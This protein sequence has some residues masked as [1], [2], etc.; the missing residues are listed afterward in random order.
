[1]R[2]HRFLA[3]LGG[4]P[5]PIALI[6]AEY[7]PLFTWLSAP[8]VP[9]LNWAGVAEAEAAAPALVVGFADMYLPALIGES[10]EHRITRL[11]AHATASPARARGPSRLIRT[12]LLRLE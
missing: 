6:L 5:D 8:F 9:V 7:T 4:E 1:M 12:T 2:L 11:P 10:I 3:P